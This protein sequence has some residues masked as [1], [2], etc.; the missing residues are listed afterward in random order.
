MLDGGLDQM[1]REA[2]AT[3]APHY[4]R[5]EVWEGK[6]RLEVLD[7][8]QGDDE[9]LIVLAGSSVSATL[10]TQVARNLTL[11]VP[12]ELYPERET[13][14]LTPNGRELRVWRGVLPP[15]GFRGYIWRVFRGKIQDADID[16]DTGQTVITASDRAQNVVDADFVRPENSNVGADRIAEMR[17]LITAVVPD[18]EFGDSDP[19]PQTMPG[20]TWEFDRGSALDEMFSTTGG[21]W[22]PLADGK[23][24]ARRYPWSVPGKPII[25]LSDGQGGVILG[26]HRRRSRRDMFNSVTAVSER[27]NGDAPIVKTV[28]DTNPDS[29]SY[30]KGPFGIKSLLMRRVSAT[31]E[32]GVLAAANARLASAITPTHQV[33]WKQVPDAALELGDIVNIQNTRRGVTRVQV[34][35]SFT[36]PLD[37]AGVMTV[38]GRAQVIKAVVTE[39]A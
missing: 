7:E 4:V 28:Q 6:T 5:V 34:V 15:D 39:D 3:Q 10:Q 9:S 27:L 25:T 2:L 23:F 32:G 13:D 16:D 20:L 22:Y 21:L 14:L 11:V 37:L 1:Y 33:N 31:T 19:F 24:V 18:A 29:P 12:E 35:S 36:L 30:I 26:T 8:F 38:Q 17:R